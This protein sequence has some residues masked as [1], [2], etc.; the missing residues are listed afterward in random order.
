[1][2]DPF[3]ISASIIGLVGLAVQTGA[4][5]SRYIA[6]LKRPTA[7]LQRLHDETTVLQ[8]VLQH[9]Q[10]KFTPAANEYTE[11]QLKAFN[12]AIKNTKRTLL[13]LSRD[14]DKLNTHRSMW[15]KLKKPKQVDRDL[16]TRHRNA[17]MMEVNILNL[18]I[19]SIVE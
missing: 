7:D 1:M 15:A 9:L 14:V 10:Y 3:S 17:L 2:G 4:S 18:L 5:L 12:D 11:Q 19:G 16:V 6:S 13:N 8:A